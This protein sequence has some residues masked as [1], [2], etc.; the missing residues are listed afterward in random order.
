MTAE[1]TARALLAARRAG[2]PAGP[3]P[4]ALRPRDLA[5]AIAA[6]I[7]LAGLLGALPP[8]GFK[9]GATGARMMAYLGVG[10]PI[11]GFMEARN[12]HADGAT[13]PFHASPRMGVECEIAVRLAGDLPPGPCDLATAAA[14]IGTVM[15]AIEIVAHRYDPPGGDLA[16]MGA[17]TLVA[18]QM[19][20]AGCVLGPEQPLGA[21]DLAAL[22]GTM[23]QDGVVFDQ[24]LGAELLGHP[25]A[26]LAWLARSAEAAAFGGLRAGQIVMLGSVT[27]PLWVEQP[28]TITVEFTALG[29]VTL[30]L[31]ADARVI[32]TG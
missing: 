6:Q 13:V 12:I 32:T 2:R 26:A 19:F 1:A 5:E 22:V 23:S 11:A 20:H 31:S 21:L 30:H 3:L 29:V 18:D 27:P 4:E 15:P 14:A 9:L 16:A 24:G 17:A 10:A 7:A 8:A 25:L 28:G